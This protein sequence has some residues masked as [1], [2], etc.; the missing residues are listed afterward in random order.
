RSC[1]I[2]WK[3]LR[4]IQRHAAGYSRRCAISRGKTC[5]TILL[6]GATGITAAICGGTQLHATAN[7]HTAIKTTPAA[8]NKAAAQRRPSPRSYKK[9]YAA[10]AFA[11][12]VREAAAGP[13]R[14]TSFQESPNSGL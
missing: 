6:H 9:T 4:S 10:M 7:N 11:T 2:S 1:S 8:T 14:L 13:I 5:R 12:K 3:I